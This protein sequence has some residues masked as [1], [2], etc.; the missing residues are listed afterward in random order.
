MFS[1]VRT[2]VLMNSQPSLASLVLALFDLARL[3]LAAD[4]ACL[5]G[6]LGIEEGRVERALAELDRRGLC[7]ARRARLSLTG[8]ALAS[9]LDMERNTRELFGIESV[10]ANDAPRSRVAA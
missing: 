8:L 1:V 2:V 9:Q 7:D 5:A 10:S 3:G 4:V 6:R